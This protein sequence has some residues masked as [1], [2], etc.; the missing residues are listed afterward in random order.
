M[1]YTSDVCTK[2]WCCTHWV[3]V[4]NTVLYTLGI[5]TKHCVVH[6]G[7]LNKTV[8]CTHWIFGQNTVF[9]RN[10]GIVHIGYLYKILYHSHLI[11]VQKYHFVHIGY[12]Y[13]NCIVHILDL[14]NQLCCT[15]QI[16]ML[17]KYLVYNK[18]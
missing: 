2:I 1:L 15:A 8:Y 10:H 14:Y 9:C 11:F 3:F 5:C 4:Q 16:V 13:K 12:L 7:Y 18:N 17:S 6:I